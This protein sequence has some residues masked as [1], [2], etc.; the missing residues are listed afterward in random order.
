MIK[1]ELYPEAK[2]ALTARL[3]EDP[4]NLELQMLLLSVERQLGAARAGQIL[5]EQSRKLADTPA[6]YRLWLEAAAAFHEEFAAL[7]R[8]LEAEQ[9]RIEQETGEWST[10]KLERRLAFAEIAGRDEHATAVIDMLR[11][12][13]ETEPPPE[14]R[15]RLR[16]Q[17]IALLNESG[18]APETLQQELEA[19]AGE[20]PRYRHEAAARLAILYAARQRHDLAMKHLAQVDLAKLNDPDLLGEIQPLLKNLPDGK[21]KMLLVT[22]RLTALN[23]TDR[24]NWQNWL[25]ALAAAGEEPRLRS[26]I[27]RLLAGVEKMP[28]AEE[29]RRLLRTHLAD[30]YWRSIGRLA[31]QSDAAALSEALLLLDSVERM[32]TGDRRWLWIAW[33]RAYLLNRL[34]RPAE[35]D[36]AIAELD[37]L[38][39]EATAA[40][41][42]AA[43][44]VASNAQEKGGDAKQPAQGAA[45]PAA[46]A[47]AKAAP[48]IAFPDGMSVTLD[49][50]KRILTRAAGLPPA[51]LNLESSTGPLPEFSTAWTFQ[52]PKSAHLTAALS[53]GERVLLADHT[54]AVYC[55]NRET[56]KLLWQ[57]D[58]A[59]PAVTYATSMRQVQVR[60]ATGHTYYQNVAY[61]YS[62]QPGGSPQPLVGENDVF[63]APGESEVACYALAD[64]EL[65]WRAYVGGV[66]AEKKLAARRGKVIVSIFLYG[67]LLVTY[68]PA[69]GTVTKIDPKTGKVLWD[70]VVMADRPS[71]VAYN[72]SGASLAGDRLLVYGAKT[73]ILNLKSGEIEWSFEP[74]VVREFPVVLK[75]PA[76]VKAEREE[77]DAMALR[78][79][80][81]TLPPWTSPYSSRTLAARGRYVTPSGQ[82]VISGP[83]PPVNVSGRYIGPSTG[84]RGSYQPNP[85]MQRM[86][87]PGGYAPR[88]YPSTAVYGGRYVPG[89]AMPY[90]A[91][92]YSGPAQP[93]HYVNF[94]Q[95]GSA[96]P[97][98][99][100]VVR[101]TGPAV[102]WAAKAAQGTAQS[103]KLY[104]QRLLLADGSGLRVLHTDLPLAGKQIFATGRWV[105]MAGPTAC[106]LNGGQLALAD[107]DKGN[108]KQV[109]LST[110]SKGTLKTQVQVTIDGLLV[111]VTGPGGVLCVNA[112]TGN[113]VFHAP[114]P[115]ELLPHDDQTDRLHASSTGHA[116]HGRPHAGHGHSHGPGLVAAPS[117]SVPISQPPGSATAQST[118]PAE[119]IGFADRGILLT[120]IGPG[121]VAA[122]K[123]TPAHGE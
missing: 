64:G 118:P 26:A 80:A 65:Q 7:G 75:D 95:P 119:I 10:R 97:S 100:A 103:G 76:E 69:S 28:L 121:R 82:V 77:A 21:R 84:I 38:V 29:T 8:F 56:G 30:S 1:K 60:S 108:L 110:V 41:R 5:I 51:D 50:A 123:G 88:S 72:S 24:D 117:R 115:A 36:E 99:T 107:I 73:A 93:T 48:A 104:G 12:D 85:H 89:G 66:G 96:P 43:E 98:G 90:S 52:A 113:R 27:R 23:P 13:L 25:S 33:T 92:P 15:K 94:L 55:V 105:G 40:A 20:D 70:A 32:S 46:L 68:E 6:R 3:K 71:V 63:Y 79:H 44:K 112:R 78:P 122:L 57:R 22:E 31:V 39:A 59:L 86:A 81:R 87:H 14:I 49:H 2:K 34:G 61:T 37:R 19:L 67:D 62:T 106:F 4:N 83:G 17:L 111:Y 101:L 102:A 120:R 91:V 58:K 54:G 109:D 35:R 9:A 74:A 53:A 11:R 116:G 16:K 45:A 42:Q 114:W 47:K 18:A